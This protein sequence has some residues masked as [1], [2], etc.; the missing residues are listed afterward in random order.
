MLCAGERDHMIW[1]TY[2][3]N[4]VM[5]PAIIRP[6]Y[7]VDVHYSLGLDGH[8]FLQHFQHARLNVRYRSVRLC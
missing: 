2:L 1:C 3:S 6:H 8:R 4:L 5:L 7:N